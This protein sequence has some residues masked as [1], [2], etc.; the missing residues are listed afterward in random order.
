MDA[1]HVVCARRALSAGEQVEVR[2]EP[3]PPP[4]LYLDWR[5]AQQIGMSPAA[6]EADRAVYTAPFV[7][8][9]GSPS[10]EIRVD[11]SGAQTGRVGFVGRVDLVSSDLPHSA[12]CLAAN[13]VV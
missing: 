1:Y 4:G 7:I 11:L 10:A 8:E 2:L 5:N 6:A 3:A 9:P 13:H 12:D